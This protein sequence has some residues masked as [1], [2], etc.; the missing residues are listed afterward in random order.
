MIAQNESTALPA[1]PPRV[2]VVIPCFNLG[3][4]VDEAVGSVLQQSFP[5]VEIIIVNDGSTDVAT[6]DL[7]GDYVRPKTRV[8]STE[9]RGLARARNLGISMARGEYVCALDADDRLHPMHLE[10]TVRV[11]D[12]RPDL[13]FASCW[14]QS[15]GDE[16]WTWKQ[17]R[18]D[19]PTLLGECTVC[20][21][22]LVRTSAVRAVGGFDERMPD[23]GYEDWELWINLVANGYPGTIIPEVLF[24][25]RRRAGSMS[26]ICCF[27]EPHQRLMR[28]LVHKHHESYDRHIVDVLLRKE[29]EISQI[30]RTNLE[31]ER[32][33][34]TVLVPELTRRREELAVL[35]HKLQRAEE[36]RVLHSERERLAA[37]VAE[38]ERVTAAVTGSIS[39]KITAPLRA[40]YDALG[41]LL[42]RAK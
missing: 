24:Y 10:R 36:E 8:I 11:L 3:Q 41:R 1:H 15:F 21:A 18:C 27:G 16:E 39:W 25:Y 7:L 31:S 4:Y 29:Q 30:L 35:N 20:T 42:N 19:F 34:Q 14:L 38:L 12:E 22:S 6:R 28:Y 23:Q 37:R 33:I 26:S 2:S 17:E 13:A 32:Q 5:D 9:N 40:T